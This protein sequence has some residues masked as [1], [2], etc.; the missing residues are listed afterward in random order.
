[1]KKQMLRAAVWALFIKP[2]K[3]GSEP[4]SK[5]NP[6]SQLRH[7]WEVRFR[8]YSPFVWAIFV[9][10]LARGIVQGAALGLVG[11]IKGF[12]NP[13]RGEFAIKLDRNSNVQWWM[14]Y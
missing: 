13:Q 9:L 8:W 5:N 14:R 4:V 10:S 2:V 12:A 7:F 11:V 1:M 6:N 3:M